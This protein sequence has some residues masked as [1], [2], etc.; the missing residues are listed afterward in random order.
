MTATADTAVFRLP[1]FSY[2]AVLFLLLCAAPL[3]LS[4]DGGDEGASVG[5]TWRAVLL[6][7]PVLAALFIARTATVVSP[8]GVTVRALFGSR[9]L[10]W[11]QVRG[12]SVSERSVYAVIDDGAVRLPCVRTSDLA[13]VSRAS[14]GRLPQIADP[15][16]KYAPGRRRRRVR[17]S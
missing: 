14:G 17:R 12:L 13:A 2:L 16:R 7:V 15:V 3:A 6:A 1:G 11:D 10:P 9:R 4:A 8:D 5:W